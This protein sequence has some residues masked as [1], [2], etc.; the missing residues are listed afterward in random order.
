MNAGRL[1]RSQV[2][3]ATRF[4]FPLATRMLSAF[5]DLSYYPQ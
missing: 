3:A 1:H 2:S 4:I 5:C